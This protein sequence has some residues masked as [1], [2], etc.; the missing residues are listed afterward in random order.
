MNGFFAISPI[1]VEE[2]VVNSIEFEEKVINLDETERYVLLQKSNGFTDKEIGSS[3]GISHSTV[4]RIKN[5]AVIKVNSECKGSIFMT[6]IKKNH[7][8][9]QV[10]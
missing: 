2:V 6:R 3:L 10:I 4:C 5:K 8:L 1:N 7:L 9:Q